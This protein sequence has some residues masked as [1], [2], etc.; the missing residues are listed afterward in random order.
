MNATLTA[1]NHAVLHQLLAASQAF[2][3]HGKGTTN[4]CPMALS[5]L[6]GMQADEARLR[7]FFAHWQEKFAIEEPALTITVARDAWRAQLGQYDNFAALQRCF[8]DWMWESGVDVVLQEVLGSIEFAPASGAFHSVIRLAYG[9]ENG[10]V[11]EV[12]AGLAAMVVSHLPLPAPLAAP[13][14]DAASALAQISAVMAGTDYEASWITARL[15]AVA[16]DAR[17]AANLAPIPYNAALIEEL[18]KLALAAYWQTRDF[19]VLHMVTGMHAVR[20]LFAR[21]PEPLVARL[22]PPLWSAV[23]GAYASVGAP[24]LQTHAQA[25]ADAAAQDPQLEAADWGPVLAKARQSN[26]DHVIKLI[27]SCQEENRH[28]PDPLYFAV[29]RRMANV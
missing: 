22:L 6:A 23:A 21:L 17:F 29:A 20:L 8:H 1:D 14:A 3:L 5:A 26:N 7:E 9:L 12:A 10:N 2:A 18:A 27:Y 16:A 15:R 11:C 13:A 24:A 25:L 28:R 4:H 19:T